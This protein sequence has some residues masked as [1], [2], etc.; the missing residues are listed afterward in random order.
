MDEINLP[1]RFFYSPGSPQMSPAVT[2]SLRSSW[3][4]FVDPKSSVTKVNTVILISDLSKGL[5]GVTVRVLTFH[6]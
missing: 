2:G 5:G 6:L 4:T 3:L 1:K